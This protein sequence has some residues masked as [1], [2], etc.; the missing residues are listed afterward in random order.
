MQRIFKYLMCIREKCAMYIGHPQLTA[1]HANFCAFQSGCDE[2]YKEMGMKMPDD[3][4][5]R[6][7][8][9]WASNYYNINVSLNACSFIKLFSTDEREAY[10]AFWV[11]LDAFLRENP[12]YV[13]DSW[14]ELAEKKKFGGLLI[15]EYPELKKLADSLESNTT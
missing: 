2:V 6:P 11:M 12:D 3:W 1:L 15:D 8:N 4:F 9:K 5:M 10:G 14:W 7:F 13:D